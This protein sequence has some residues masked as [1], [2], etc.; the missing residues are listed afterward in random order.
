MRTVFDDVMEG[1]DQARRYAGGEEVP[2]LVVHVPATLDVSGIRAKS[3]M[4]QPAFAGTVGVKLAT[5]RQWE[6][7]RRAP[8]GPARVLLAMVDRNPRIV[9]ETLGVPMDPSVGGPPAAASRPRTKGSR[10]ATG[11]KRSAPLSS[12]R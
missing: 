7:G 12:G 4:S 6:Q 3:G 9:M 11:S 8:E 2:G 5:L 1:L 10:I